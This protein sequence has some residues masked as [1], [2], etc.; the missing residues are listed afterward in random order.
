MADTHRPLVVAEG[1]GRDFGEVVALESLDLEMAGGQAVALIGHN[2]SGKTTALSILAGR[3]E[4]TRGT[5]RIGGVDVHRRS[6]SATVRAVVSFVPDTPALYPDL[7]VEDHLDLV[8][9]AHGVEDLEE[10]AGRM[11]ELFGLA[12]R[13]HL[14][15]RE[16]SRGMRQKAQLACGLLRPFEV[17]ILDEPAS[18]LDPPSRRALHSLLQ[19]VKDEGALVVFSTHDLGFT[20]D[21]ADQIVVL[22]DGS[23][24]AAGTREEIAASVQVSDLGLA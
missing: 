22:G 19:D 18:G 9:F 16:L 7:T 20:R 4:P 11:L 14:L 23:V 12:E 1:L 3:L 2:G 17:V 10:R 15:P 13:R 24:V 5:V 6:G 21:L 8:G